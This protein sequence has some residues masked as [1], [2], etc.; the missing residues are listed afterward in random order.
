MRIGG[1]GGGGHPP[2]VTQLH[3][4]TPT[5]AN[6]SPPTAATALQSMCLSNG[7]A[8]RLMTDGRYKVKAATDVTGFGLMGHLVEMLGGGVGAMIDVRKVP[9]FEGALE[10][11]EQVRRGGERGGGGEREKVK[12]KGKARHLASSTPSLPTHSLTGDIQQP[13]GEQRVREKVRCQPRVNGQ[14]IAAP[15]QAPLRPSNLRRPHHHRGG[16]G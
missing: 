16:G 5:C 3:T 2:V 1:G 12:E 9:I 7:K 6:P 4:H 11:A 15:L 10:A 8:G 14:E 13:P